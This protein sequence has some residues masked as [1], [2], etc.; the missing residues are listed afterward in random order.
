MKQSSF[1]SQFL[2]AG[3]L[4]LATGIATAE[5]PPAIQALEAR[6]LTIEAQFEAPGGL[7]GFVG[8]ANGQPLTVY[9]TEDGEHAIIGQMVD[10][11]A[12]NLSQD[13]LDQHTPRP[14]LESAWE[15]LEDAHWIVEGDPNAE[16]VVYVFTDPNCPY[17]NAFW[18]AARPYIGE[19]VQLRHIM[20]AILREDSLGKSARILAA[21]S[22]AETLQRHERSHEEG[23]ITP[24]TDIPNDIRARIQANTDLMRSLGAH[25][26]PAI[27]FR[28]SNGEVRQRMGMQPLRVIA[29]EI[30][31][32]PLQET[33]DPSLQR[34]R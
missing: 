14:D 25:A 32:Q 17:C 11:Q 29:E 4:L 23:G 13:H 5:R 27:F 20:V 2:L 16:R 3:L 6:G 24:M 21:D 7:T 34:Y 15:R 28:D 31:D 8:Q 9:V 19:A 26:T 1:Y 10:D 33:D 22:P 12:Q 18:R 30:F